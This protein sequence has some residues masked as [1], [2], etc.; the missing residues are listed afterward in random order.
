MQNDRSLL[1]LPEPLSKII[2]ALRCSTR[3]PSRAAE[4]GT[5]PSAPAHKTKPVLYCTLITTTTFSRQRLA[6]SARPGNYLQ[7]TN[8][9]H[10]RFKRMVKHRYKPIS[11]S[12]IS[13]L[14]DQQRTERV[15]SKV[16]HRQGCGHVYRR[17]LRRRRRR[18]LFFY[19]TKDRD[20]GLKAFL[21]AEAQTTAAATTSASVRRSIVMRSQT[22]DGR[23]ASKCLRK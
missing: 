20:E 9:R 1:L 16:G 15:G 7:P 11:N 12:E 3:P 5:R 21:H 22:I 6:P 10:L 13:T 2:T 14:A 8:G 17:R 19:F 4:D 18:V 23:S